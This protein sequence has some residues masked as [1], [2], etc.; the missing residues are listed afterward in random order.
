MPPELKSK[1]RVRRPSNADPRLYRIHATIRDSFEAA[2][3][4]EDIPKR[5]DPGRYTVM[6]SV[7]SDPKSPLVFLKCDAELILEIK[8]LHQENVC[9]Q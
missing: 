2:I 8:L 7:F 1:V 3:T 4:H 9:E 6:E 5:A